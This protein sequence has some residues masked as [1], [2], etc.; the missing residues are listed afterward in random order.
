VPAL[1]NEM[2]PK[3]VSILAADERSR[4]EQLL[5]SGRLNPVLQEGPTSRYAMKL[6]PMLAGVLAVQSFGGT[7][8]GSEAARAELVGIALEAAKI[9]PA[10]VTPQLVTNMVEQ[11]TGGREFYRYERPADVEPAAFWAILSIGAA[12]ARR[13]HWRYPEIA[14]IY[15]Q[16][17]SFLERSGW[18]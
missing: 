8:P 1:V 13:A 18:R 12:A 10:P 7:L 4:L 9:A 2:L 17:R 11:L 14:R 5:R 16:A 6:A 15:S 3:L